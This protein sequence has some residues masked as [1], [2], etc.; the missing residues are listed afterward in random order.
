MRTIG[1]LTS[2]GDA[3]GMNAAVRAVVRGAISLDMRV[4]GIEDGYDGLLKGNMREMDVKSVSD[5]LQR[6]GTFLRTARCMEMMTEEGVKRA[7]DKASLFD[8]DGLVVIGGDGSFNG[9]LALSKQ[10]LRTACV[11][12]TIDNDLAYT[13]WT[14]GFDTA[15]NTCVNAINLI[16]DTS[17]SHGRITVIEVMGRH[18][19]DI[20]LAAGVAG[21]AAYVFIPEVEPNL[22][23][24][25]KRLDRGRARGKRHNIIIRAEGARIGTDELVNMIANHTQGEVRKVVLGYLQRGGTPTANDRIIASKMGFRAVEILAGE[26]NARA[27]GMHGVEVFDMDLAEALNMARIVDTEEIRLMETLAI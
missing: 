11:P 25:M 7:I 24:L 1:V 18:C 9:A 5:V 21:G 17:A 15:V 16:R 2:G 12:A 14:I 13:D 8:L 22:D 19:G 3:P 26:G 23:L 27:V 4:Y 20:A 10:G 6:G